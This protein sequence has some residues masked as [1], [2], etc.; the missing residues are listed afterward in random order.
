MRTSNLKIGW[1]LDPFTP[2][3]HTSVGA[4]DVG[5]TAGWEHGERMSQLAVRESIPRRG[6]GLEGGLE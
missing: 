2:V 6:R 5:P 3:A 1:L 4:I